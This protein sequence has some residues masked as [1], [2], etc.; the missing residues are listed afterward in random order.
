[1]ANKQ[2]TYRCL[3]GTLLGLTSISFNSYAALNSMDWKAAGDELL[4]YD[5]VTNLYW[6]DLSETYG[7]AYND[8]VPELAAGGDYEGFRYAS[9]AE[10]IALWANF[11]IDLSAG[12]ATS[13]PGYD[14]NIENVS[15]Y[16]GNNWNTYASWDYPFGVSG[17]TAD[18]S[19]SG[20]YALGATQTDWAFNEYHV[21]GSRFLP[22]SLT[23]IAPYG[24]YLVMGTAV[25]V[26]AAIWLM[27]SGLLGMIGVARSK[28]S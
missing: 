19:S 25:P 12:A 27:A 18:A 11:S 14:V 23:G 26:P 15:S 6:L 24:S 21:A 13:S 1:M 5:N 8:V 4:T 9:N 20:R 10:V 2:S 7:I 3:L 28:S 17:I 16:L 22:D